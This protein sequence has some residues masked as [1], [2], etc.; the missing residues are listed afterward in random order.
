M[1]SE[2]K[3]TFLQDFAIANYFGTDAITDTFNRAFKEWKDNPVYLAELVVVLNWNIWDWFE[4]SK[5]IAELYNELWE[6]AQEYGYEN[7]EGEDL[8]KFLEIID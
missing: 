3:T 6:Q 4:V 2:F 1:I 7:F 5:P 8:E